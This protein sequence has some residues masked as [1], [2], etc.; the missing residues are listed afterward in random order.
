MKSELLD[1]LPPHNRDAEIGVLGSVLLDPRRLDD[2]VGSLTTEDFYVEAHKRIYGHCLAIRDSRIGLDAVTL[3]QR[4][5]EA[6]DVEK[7][8]GAAYLAE[9]VHAVPHAANAVYYGRI[10]TEQAKRRRVIQA[11]SA[12]VV[13]AWDATSSVDEVVCLCEA[14]LRKIPTGEYTGEPVEFGKAL[15]A[16]CDAV[17][18]IASRKRA[19]GVMIGLENFDYAAGGFFP[20]ELVI[21]AARPSIGKTSLGLQIAQHVAE[22]GKGVYFA[23]LEMRTTELALRVLCG[24][25]GV[26]M[27]RVRSAEIGPSDTADLTRSSAALY[28]LP[29]VLHDRAGLSVQD[30][31][32]ACRRLAAK[33]ALGLVVVDYLQRVTPSDRR[34]DRHLQVGQITWDLKALALELRVPILC[35]CQLG[36]AAEERDRKT[37]LVVEPR[38]SFLKESGDIEQ[39]VDMVLLLHRQQ[40]ATEAVMILAKNRQGEQARFNLMWDGPRTRFEC[41]GLSGREKAFDEF[42]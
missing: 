27:A 31:A 13:A 2:L 15:I 22:K 12:M 11:G 10:V 19:A 28:R 23:S 6:G 39:D 35:L 20:G 37:G 16:A 25:A 24:H 5:S 1:R 36:R 26:A 4:L 32:R 21:L 9:V 34:A 30:I 17:D 3:L 7:V 8:G 42:S 33:D 18:E 29:I 38:L 41:A 40:R 14:E